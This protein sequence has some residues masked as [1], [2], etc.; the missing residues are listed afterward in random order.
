MRCYTI[1]TDGADILPGLA[2]VKPKDHS[3][4]FVEIGRKRVY[5]SDE[6]IE[7]APINAF[8]RLLRAEPITIGNEVMLAPESEDSGKAL[9][10]FSTNIWAANRHPATT[11]V[12]IDS[13]AST[14]FLDDETGRE[15][16][17]LARLSI[18]A[19]IGADQEVKQKRPERQPRTLRERW[20][21]VPAEFDVH[22]VYKPIAVFDGTKL[23]RVVVAESKA[24][25][26]QS[27]VMMRMIDPS[28]SMYSP[29]D[30]PASE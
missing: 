22:K 5:L 18:G 8:G 11:D 7:L 15:H 4:P 19:S 14:Y 6:L 16:Y 30:L 25:T 23:R 26:P 1:T 13:V 12:L 10:L 21:G 3:R 29:L 27:P 24:G 2:V 20:F 28:G 9:V 17:V